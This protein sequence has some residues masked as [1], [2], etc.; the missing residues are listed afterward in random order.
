MKDVGKYDE[1]TLMVDTNIDT[2][3]NEHPSCPIITNENSD[4]F[5][6]SESGL[7]PK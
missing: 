1:K 2:E 7:L 4:L 3:D 6:F 5:Q